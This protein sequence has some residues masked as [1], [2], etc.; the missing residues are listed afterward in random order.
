MTVP[1]GTRFGRYEIRS[2]IRKGGMGEVYLAQ[3][4]QLRRQV[5]IKVLTAEFTQDQDR[6]HRFEHESFA[7]SSLNHPNILTIHE[8]G[9][10]EGTHYI[11]TEYIDGESLRDRLHHSRM[12]LREVLEVAIQVASALSAAH[13]AGIVHRDIKPENIMLRRDGYVKVLDFGLAKLTDTGTRKHEAEDA[14]TRVMIKTD[15]G[16]VMGTSFYMSPEQ[17]RAQEVDART[18]IWSLGCVIYEMVTGRMPFEGPTTSDVIGFILHKEPPPLVRHSSEIPAELDRIVTKALEKDREERYQVVKDLALDLKKLKQH[19]EFE[20]ELERTIAPEERSWSTHKTSIAERST[21]AAKASATQ[22]DSPA[23]VHTASSAEYIVSQI[24]THKKASA[25]MA[26][27]F[28][29]AVA[30]GLFFYLK[31]VSAL[32][33]KDTILIADFV[34]TTADTVFD[35]TLKQGLAVQLSQS[36]FLNVFPDARVRQTLR[37]MG[38]SPDERVTKD[39]AREICQR[40]GLKAFLSGSIN[41]LGTSYVIALEAINGQS[42]EEIAREQVEAENKE[43]VLKALT[44]AASKLRQKLGESLSSIQKFDAPLELTTS[45]L[46]ALKASSMAYE[47]SS[48]GRFLESIPFYKRAVELDPNFAYAYAGLAVQY[49]NTNQPKL[50]AE[51]AEKAFTLRDRVS[52]LEKLRI[53]SFYYT[54]V[55]G[56]VDKQIEVLELYKRTYPRDHRAPGN[57]SDVYVR[58]GQFEKAAVEANNALKLNPISA[59]SRVNLA[60]AFMSLNRFDDARGVLDQAIQENID[61]TLL[62]AMKYQLAMINGDVTSSKEQIDWARGKPDEYAALDWQTQIEAFSGHLRRSQDLSRSAIDMAMRSDAKEIAA[63]YAVDAALRDAVLGQCSE[64]KAVASESAGLERN[65]LSRRRAA[66]A[67]ALCGDSGRAQSVIVEVTKERATD[68]LI[69]SLWVPGIRAAIEINRNNPSEAIKLLDSAR[70][71]EPAAEFWPQY[72]RGVAYLRL[73]SGNEAAAEFQKILDNR[74]QAPLSVLYPLAHLGLARAAAL[75]GDVSKSRQVYQDFLALWKD[76][77]SDLPVLQEARLEY[78]KVK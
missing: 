56:E 41:N 17:A 1:A 38:R 43:Q 76:A 14:P 55:T 61:A 59:A 71:F 54:F 44:Q 66:L 7:A 72:L 4:T 65:I 40:Q 15:P 20:L 27:A 70:R 19:T 36:P 6:L 69:N 75:T 78:E 50:A 21:E 47:Q 30:A 46:D 33:D 60:Q 10:H 24:K 34:N 48:R 63:Q 49:S 62:R 67:L 58:V 12:H 35:G 2:L 37:L 5:A 3:D 73:K 13:Q 45:S 22:T 18:D 52:E 64:S 39:V 57:L 25:L 9:S 28:V 29:I 16:V 31:P 74:G 42:G 68:T 26:A 77:D 8:I 11:A 53:S 51:Y 23:V 32:T